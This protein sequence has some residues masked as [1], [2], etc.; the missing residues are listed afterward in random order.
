MRSLAF[1][2]SSPPV[3]FDPVRPVLV[4]GGLRGRGRD[5]LSRMSAHISVFTSPGWMTLAVTP[6]PAISAARWR[7]NWFSAALLVP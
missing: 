1:S 4:A 2:G 6:L 5:A 7:V 3:R